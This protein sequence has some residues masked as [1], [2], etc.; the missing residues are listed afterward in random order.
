MYANLTV[1]NP[2]HSIWQCKEELLKETISWSIL[3][4]VNLGDKQHQRLKHDTSY[5]A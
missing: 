4:Q 5:P 3:A 1:S 2:F